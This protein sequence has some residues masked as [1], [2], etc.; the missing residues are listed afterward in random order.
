MGELTATSTHLSKYDVSTGEASGVMSVQGGCLVGNDLYSF[1]VDTTFTSYK[2]IKTDMTT[3][4]S[5][6]V[7]TNLSL[8]HAND[9]TYNPHEDVIVVADGNDGSKL[10]KITLDGNYSV[11]TVD[12]SNT[13]TGIWAIAY[14]ATNKQYIGA[15]HSTIHYY[16]SNFNLLRTVEYSL[17]QGYKGQGALT[18]GVYFY[19]LESTTTND[20]NNLLVFD[21]VTGEKIATVDIGITRESENIVYKD[22]KFFV[23]CNNTGWTGMEV[24]EVTVSTAS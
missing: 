6:V 9:A 17:S 4:D 11:T 3:G 14:D 2:M 13:S 20:N 23:T 1:M 5:V 21:L 22:G 15:G 16:D 19:L 18:D 24:Y 10:Y 12:I 8:G 7:A